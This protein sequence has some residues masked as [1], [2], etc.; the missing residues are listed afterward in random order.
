VADY[1]VRDGSGRVIGRISEAGPGCLGC[2][3][4]SAIALVIWLA[5][6]AY[7]YVQARRALNSIEA[8]RVR[9]SDEAL[10][11]LVGEYDYGRY[12]IQVE[13]RG[14]R[15]YNKSDE[16]FCELVPISTQEFIYKACVNGFQ[17]RGRFV[18]DE[19]GKL[20]LIIIHRDGRSE[21]AARVN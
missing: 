4:V 16:E 21:K 8:Q 13:R 6:N 11:A 20:A 14:D 10:D 17:G 19:R 9:L 18:K 3:S 1:V 2:L 5:I 7:Q 15:L 12:R